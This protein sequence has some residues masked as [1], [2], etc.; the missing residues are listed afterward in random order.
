MPK[1]HVVKLTINNKTDEVM[2]Y[3]SDWFDSGRVADSWSWPATISPGSTQIVEC[4]EKDYALAGCSGYVNYTLGTGEVTIAF[5][6]PSV[7]SNKLGVGVGGHDVW[8][9][10][11]SH[12]YK[13]FTVGFKVEKDKFMAT[14]CCTGGD[15]NDA[16]VT[17]E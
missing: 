2:N 9:K 17:L 8:D 7:G 11:D 14:C 6:N 10:M 13:E 16:Q 4:Y 5:S 1:S 12:D 15:V 3:K